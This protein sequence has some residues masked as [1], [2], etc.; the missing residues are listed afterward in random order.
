MFLRHDPGP[1]YL[2]YEIVH[3]RFLR[4]TVD[5][6][7]PAGHGRATTWWWTSHEEL[8]WRLRALA[9]L[10]NTLGKRIVAIG[11]AAGWGEGGQ[12]APDDLQGTSGSSTWWIIPTRTSSRASRRPCQNAALVK[13][14]ASAPPARYLKQAG[15]HARTPPASSSTTPSS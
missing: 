11:G 10:K 5:E 8:L 14:A 6:Y 3:P 2:W 4:K 9:G 12:K 13:L 7:A 1:V 15:H